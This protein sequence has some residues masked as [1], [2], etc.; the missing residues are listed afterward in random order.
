MTK[1]FKDDPLI[2]FGDVDWSEENLQRVLGQDQGVGSGGWPTIRYYNK[3]TGYGGKPYKKKTDEELCDEL[4]N[5][6]RLKDYFQEKSG[7]SFC[8]VVWGSDCGDMEL[9]YVAKW[10][11]PG[12]QRSKDIVTRER[13][14]RHQDLL[15]GA[16]TFAQ[17]QQRVML[18][19]R[20]LHNW[21][22]PEL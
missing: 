9:K 18:L 17:N 1:Q 12:A 20:I 8:D 7:T 13:D 2:S 19:T 14:K 10:V 11:G 22:N 15:A 3:A 16:G 21:D 4:G 5:M 6:D